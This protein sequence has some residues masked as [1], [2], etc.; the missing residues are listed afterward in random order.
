MAFYSDWRVGS[1]FVLLTF[2]L[3]ATMTGI[4][5]WAVYTH[6]TSALQETLVKR[7]QSISLQLMSDRFY[8]TTVIVP[9]LVALG[10]SVVADYHRISGL[11]PLPATF[12]R[13]VSELTA[14]EGNGYRTSLISLWP[15]NKEKGVTD[16]FQREAFEYLQEHPTG[17][18]YRI[19]TVKGHAVFRF[20]TADRAISQSCIDCHNAHPASPKRDFKL[21]D[22]MGG[23]ETTIPVDQ[24]L[25][26]GR[27][28]LLLTVAGGAGFCLLL[29][30]AVAW[31]ARRA[32]TKP[33]TGLGF[34]LEKRFKLREMPLGQDEIESRGNELNHFEEIFERIQSVMSTQ[35]RQIQKELVDLEA[36]NRRLK[37]E[38]A[39]R[40]KASIGSE[41]GGSTVSGQGNEALIYVDAAGLIQGVNGQAEVITGRPAADL[42]GRSFLTLLSL[43]SAAQAHAW[44]T[45]LHPGRTLPSREELQLITASGLTVRLEVNLVGVKEGDS[46]RTGM[47]LSARLLSEKH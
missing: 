7:A 19:D 42:I 5:A 30:G 6:N 12:V 40:T 16:K 18:F 34:R 38:L 11:F 27:R 17:Q 35:Q 20:V 28:R 26:E 25:K 36:A 3:I 15:I 1:K 45:G 24:Y 39:E 2:P 13:E 21:N 47:I 8:Y 4:A 22:V 44:I 37:Q 46:G 41:P 33:L 29:M 14:A 32:V 10:G 23:L 43:D 31:G 9:R